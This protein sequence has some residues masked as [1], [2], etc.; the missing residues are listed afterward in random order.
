MQYIPDNLTNEQRLAMLLAL[1]KQLIDEFNQYADDLS[2]EAHQARAKIRPVLH[3]IGGELSRLRVFIERDLGLPP[4]GEETLG[5]RM[6]REAALQDT[7]PG[8]VKKIVNSILRN[9]TL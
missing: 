1:K 2:S 5:A 4:D 6:E 7:R 8:E 3:E 9:S